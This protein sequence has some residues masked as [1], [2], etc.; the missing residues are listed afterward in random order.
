[1]AVT[2]LPLRAPACAEC[3]GPMPPMKGTG[4]PRATCSERCRKR[5]SRRRSALPWPPVPPQDFPS[6]PEVVRRRTIEALVATMEGE[7]PAPAEDQLAQGLL[8][9]DWL[10]YRLAK[11]ERDLPRRL[12]G[13][14]AELARRIRE[15]R[16]ALFPGIE[17]AAL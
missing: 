10:A 9:I 12:A 13:P 1:M 2:R 6:D 7:R 4:R 5:R 3:G 8:E 14:A 17:E 16:L 15:A 11:L